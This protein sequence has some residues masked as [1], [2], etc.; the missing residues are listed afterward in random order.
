MASWDG[1]HVRCALLTRSTHWVVHGR[2]MGRAWQDHARPCTIMTL[3][4]IMTGLE[5]DSLPCGVKH[6]TFP[7][8]ATGR[9]AG[10][11][12][13]HGRRIGGQTRE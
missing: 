13:S 2:N 5:P 10:Q 7:R 6:R 8:A 12:E 1:P 9:T 4:R 3:Q 11:V